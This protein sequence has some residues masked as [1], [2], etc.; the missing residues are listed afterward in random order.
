MSFLLSLNSK[1]R[2]RGVVSKSLLKLRLIS[3]EYGLRPLRSK[4]S[5][6]KRQLLPVSLLVPLLLQP[7]RTYITLLLKLR[8][9]LHVPLLCNLLKRRHTLVRLT[10][11]LGLCL[12]LLLL[13]QKVRPA[14]ESLQVCTPCIFHHAEHVQLRA[15]IAVRVR[16]R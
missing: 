16:G 8:L 7:R 6:L 15:D 13:A 1:I 11:E 4:P 10:A 3:P 5:V 2:K 14:D 9:L 12:L